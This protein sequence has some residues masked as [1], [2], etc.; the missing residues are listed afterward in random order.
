[1][2]RFSCKNCGQKL[3]VRDQHSG[4]RVKCSKCGSVH[5][6]PD[7]SDKIKFHCESCGQSIHVPQIHA[8]K[9][10]RCPKCKSPVVI[11]SLKKEPADGVGTVSIVCSMCE[12][13]I[14]VP[15]T[16]I[17]KLIECAHCGCY[18]EVPTE[19][20][21]AP[22]QTPREDEPDDKRPEEPQG[23]E[24][25]VAVQENAPAGKR[26]LPWLLDVFLYPTSMSGLINLGIFWILP[27]VLGVIARILPIPFIWSIASLIVAAYMYYYFTECIR[28]SAKGGIRAPENIGSMPDM[29]DT[30]SQMMEIVASIVIFWGPIGAYSMYKIF[31]QSSGTRSAY[32][33]SADAIFWLLWGY[34]IFFFPMGLLALIM[35]GSPS[36]FNPFLWIASI[37]ST[38][39]RYFCLVLLF[40]VLGWLASKVA[41]SFLLSPFF[42]YF[43]GAAFIYLAMVAAHLL[44][45]FYYLNSEKL[46]WEA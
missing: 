25:E 10:G 33:P 15:E 38:F 44:G 8:G 40:C 19:K 4:K 13:T 7:N 2:I 22:V 17:G 45:R 30:V 20:T 9:K 31:W 3:S 43:F 24:G 14:Q 46:N 21:E 36:A 29:G 5:V 35:L 11:P 34:G 16:S 18:V 32:E 28:D 26:K 39:F 37:F 6:V 27:I 12:E 42:A 23:P 1:M 41:A